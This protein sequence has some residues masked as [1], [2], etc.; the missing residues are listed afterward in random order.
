[1]KT[2]GFFFEWILYFFLT[3]KE[4][5]LY[6]MGKIRGYRCIGWKTINASARMYSYDLTKLP[7]REYLTWLEYWKTRKFT[8]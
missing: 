5:H 2:I 6:S 8:K 3:T 4:R 7:Y 1:M